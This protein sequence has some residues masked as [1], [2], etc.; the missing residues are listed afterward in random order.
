MIRF[1]ASTEGGQHELAFPQTIS[2]IPLRAYIAIDEQFRAHPELNFPTSPKGWNLS[3]YAA[4]LSV[5]Q[6]ILK[7]TVHPRSAAEVIDHIPAKGKGFSMMVNVALNILTAINTYA[8]KFRNEFTYRGETFTVPGNSVQKIGPMEMEFVGETL[9]LGQLVEAYA[10][11]SLFESKDDDGNPLF[12]D[13]RFW[14]D[15]AIVAAIAQK[16]IDGKP[17]PL[18]TDLN[19]LADFVQARVNYFEDLPADVALDCGF[20]FI[21]YT[22]KSLSAVLRPYFSSRRKSPEA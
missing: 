7:A 9:T 14:S 6:N 3:K 10:K 4:I 18:P 5:V 2:E 19:G 13:A 11:L 15:V 12:Q 21:A 17:E 1:K 22:R 16:V 20:F 8:P